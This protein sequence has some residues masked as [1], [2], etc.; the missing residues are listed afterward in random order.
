MASE[1]KDLAEATE[2]Y[3]CR[4]VFNPINDRRDSG[5]AERTKSDNKKT[6]QSLKNALG[7]TQER[8][9]NSDRAT[10]SA[11]IPNRTIYCIRI[12][13]ALTAAL[14]AG[15]LIDIIL[16]AITLTLFLLLCA[17]VFIGPE[18]IFRAISREI[19][20]LVFRST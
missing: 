14:C 19:L 10:I 1:V 17:S 15:L 3:G 7:L 11:C 6:H 2:V 5:R 20:P 12:F 13:L 9:G 18:K 8:A 4:Y 16:S